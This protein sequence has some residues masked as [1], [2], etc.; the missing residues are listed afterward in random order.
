MS[1]KGS[2]AQRTIGLLKDPAFQELVAKAATRPVTPKEIGAVT[3]TP[4]FR[5]WADSQGFGAEWF[6]GAVQA[7]QGAHDNDQR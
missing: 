7:I 5:R 6:Q 2:N 4:A 1:S 3:K